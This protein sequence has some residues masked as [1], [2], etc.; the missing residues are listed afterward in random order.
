M[1]SS[2]AAKDL[3]ATRERFVDETCASFIQSGADL[4][5]DQKARVAELESRLSEI[6]QKFSEN[7]LDSTNAWELVIEDESRL[8]GLPESAKAAAAADAEGK[9][10][11]G[12]W[13][14]TLQYPSMGPV[15]QYAD[16]DDLR[17]EIWEANCTIGRDDDFD[18]TALI[19]EILELRQEKAELLGYDN[20]ADLPWSVAWRVMVRRR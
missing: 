5:A 18:N 9:G 12:K 11:E 15:L 20:F 14:F 1:L 6:T 4:P 17:R 8:A 2:A 19:W 10:H 7:V 13:R 3:D 16:D